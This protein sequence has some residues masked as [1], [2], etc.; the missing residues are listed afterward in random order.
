FAAQIS[1]DPARELGF[2]ECL[3]AILRQDPEVIMIGEIRDR[4]TANATLQ[5]ALTGHRLLS[6]MH[7]LSAAEALVRLQQMGSAA[8]VI[9]SALAGIL[10]LRLVR[11][12]CPHCKKSRELPP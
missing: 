2:A 12:L 5:A 10:N 7:T 9:S 6:S 11:L 8:Y 3:R 1:V 4:E